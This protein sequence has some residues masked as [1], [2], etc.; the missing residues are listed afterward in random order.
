MGNESSGN[1]DE[2]TKIHSSDQLDQ[3]LEQARSR[4]VEEAPDFEGSEH[5]MMGDMEA[6]AQS[7]KVVD[8]A[9]A[10]ATRQSARHIIRRPSSKPTCKQ[11]EDAFEPWSHIDA[12]QVQAAPRRANTAPIP[13]LPSLADRI[14]AKFDCDD[15]S[16]DVDE[17]VEDRVERP[18]EEVAPVGMP[19]EVSQEALVVEAQRTEPAAVVAPQQ[20]TWRWG[21]IA[22]V[23]L[24]VATIAIGGVA[25]VRLTALEQELAATKAQLEQQKP[26]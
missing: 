13:A 7:M 19:D 3:M 20:R 26:K 17:V 4:G 16:D 5:T 15:D 23:A 9:P 14:A 24:L 10:S 2:P 1:F 6:L 11:D 25:Y 8:E 12:E 18:T 22:W 21:V